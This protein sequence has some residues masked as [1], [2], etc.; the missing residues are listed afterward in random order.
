LGE[1]PG[2]FGLGVEELAQVLGGD[3]EE[4]A[5]GDY[6]DGGKI[7]E[8]L[9][10]LALAEGIARAMDGGDQVPAGIEV[11][12]FAPAADDEIHRGGGLV[13]GEDD[14]VLREVAE[15]GAGGE[16][17]KGGGREKGKKPVRPKV[18]LVYLHIAL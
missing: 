8:A 11:T 16:F 17:P 9:Q 15:A 3:A 6:R 13:L 18:A 1:P 2:Y 4:D 10:Y 14:A 7:G 5:A 12:G